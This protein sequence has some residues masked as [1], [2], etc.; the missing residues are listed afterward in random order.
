LTSPERFGRAIK[1]RL[2]DPTPVFLGG[3]PYAA[4]DLLAAMLHDVVRK[5]SSELGAPPEHI[6]LTGP[7]NWGPLQRGLFEQVTRIA[8]LD[9]AVIVSDPEAAAAHFAES[10]HPGGG[11]IVAVYDLGGGTFDAAVLRM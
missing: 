3:V 6:V 10:R 8:G 2:G 4:P 5:V 7:A 11:E 1:R 9:G